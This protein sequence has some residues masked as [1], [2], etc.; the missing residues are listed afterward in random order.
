M[1]LLIPGLL[2][3]IT[4]FA[5]SLPMV[6]YVPSRVRKKAAAREEEIEEEER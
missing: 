2:A 4:A 5:K 1:I 3:S 6:I